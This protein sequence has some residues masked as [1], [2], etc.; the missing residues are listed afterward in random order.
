MLL[1]A[2]YGGGDPAGAWLRAHLKL[3]D[4]LDEAL[5]PDWRDPGLR[6]AL[7]ALV[8][9]RLSDEGRP[10][11]DR[12]MALNVI[13]KGAGHILPKVEHL[14]ERSG[15]SPRSPLFDPELVALSFRLPPHA[16]RRGAEEKW[17]LKQAVADLLPQR[18][19]DRP[20]SGMLVPVE[21]WFQGPLAGWARERLLDGLAPR[22]I[23][24]RAWLERLCRQALGG[25]RPRHGVKI[26]LLLTLEAWL[27]VVWDRPSA[28]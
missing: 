23:V 7:R 3:W 15:C 16:K 1:D 24:D 10:L 21:A 20:K 12:L 17:L 4:E 25:L 8:A 22:R 26:W 28:R 2:I 9:P 19:L 14:A 18:I 6:D 11:L 13:W 5:D 27:R